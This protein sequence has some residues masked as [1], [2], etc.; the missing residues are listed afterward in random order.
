[1]VDSGSRAGKFFGGEIKI[2]DEQGVP[3]QIGTHGDVQRYVQGSFH[4][5]YRVSSV[6]SSADVREPRSAP[7]LDGACSTVSNIESIGCLFRLATARQGEADATI[8]GR[9]LPA[10]ESER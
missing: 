2:I 8:A 7:S 10:Y 6:V 5:H 4:H 3:L 9:L 1:M